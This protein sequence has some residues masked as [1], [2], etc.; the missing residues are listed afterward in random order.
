MTLDLTTM[1]YLDHAAT[2]F[3]K[4]PEVL[5]AV[6]RWFEDLGVS[7]QRGNSEA[8]RTVH[9]EVERVRATVARHCGVPTERLA[10][11]SGT[12]EA[13]HL[14]FGGI[15]RR[16]DHVVTTSWEHGSV[17]RPLAAA[18]DAGQIR[19]TLLRPAEPGQPPSP[20]QLA[21]VLETDPAAL[22]V[23]TEASNVTGARLD[24]A[25]L[26]ATARRHGCVTLCDVSQ[27]AGLLPEWGGH[28]DLIAGSAHKSLL[29]PPG[30]GFL[31]ARPDITVDPTKRGGTGSSVALESHPT[32]WPAAMEA[33]TPNTPAIFGLG[34]ALDWIEVRGSE[35][36]LAHGH[37]VCAAIQRELEQALG[38]R[39]RWHGLH[40]AVP[41]TPVLSFTVEGLDPEEAGMLLEAQQIHVRT[42]F[43]C[44]PWIHAELGTDAAGTIR[45]SPGPF[46]SVDAAQQVAAALSL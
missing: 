14:A 17:A 38:D 46:V 16:G 26:V 20:E 11:C 35:Q 36:L 34:A 3:P 41:R 12:T 7:A 1:L 45:V 39:L 6:Q 19:L 4:P 23:F 10:F 40:S 25:A 8:T 28:A 33:G 9:A 29:A 32:E 44:T 21:H 5:A 22:F 18:R 31:A 30:L 13:L 37:A 2:S 43:H 42:G 15:L 27:T 24:A